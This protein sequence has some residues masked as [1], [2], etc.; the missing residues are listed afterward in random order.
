M[1]N[2]DCMCA[3]NYVCDKILLYYCLT[4][5]KFFI[6]FTLEG[7]INIKTYEINACFEWFNNLF[8]LIYGFPM[9]V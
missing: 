3:C 8:I 9:Y 4:M 6:Q 2:M 5:I 7:N 1:L